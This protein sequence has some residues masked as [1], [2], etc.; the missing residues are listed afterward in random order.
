MKRHLFVRDRYFY[1]MLVTLAIPIALQNFVTFAVNFADNLMVGRLGEYVISG[2]YMGNQLQTFLQFFVTGVESGMLILAAQYWGRQ[3]TGSIRKLVNTAF[4][5][6]VSV[7]TL[8]SVIVALIP[9]KMIALFTNDANVIAEGA[10]YVQIVCWSYIFFGITQMMI[11]A[12]RSVEQSKVG[13]YVSLIALVTNITLNYILIFGKLGF[14]ALGIRGAAIA[15]LISRILESGFAVCYVLFIDQRLKMK[16]R[17]FFRALDTTLA[18]D[19]FKYG[20]PVLLGQIVWAV[21]MLSQAAIIGRMG[22]EATSAVSISGMLNN[23]LFM[24]VLGFSAALGILTGKTVGAGEYE[25][26]KSYAIT[27]QVLFGIVA[28]L[29]GAIILLL[30]NTF[31]GF[32][33]ITDQTVVV[34]KQFIIVTAIASVGRGYQG[35]CLAGLVKA[36]GDVGFVFK[37]DTIFVFLIVL[38]SALIAM[39][40]FN[41][42]AWVVYAC[43]QSDQI[44]KCFVAVVKINRFNW[45]N[46]LTRAGNE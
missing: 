6:C 31:V 33:E 11:S 32:Y 7:C 37:M 12:M 13:L 23:L 28:V 24:V 26:M 1:T 10:S 43:L 36:G 46:N 16:V 4:R 41:A 20:T 2:V 8:F 14:P 42:P 44:L 39:Y 21:N 29:T 30:K 5:F 40:A 18:R 25:K 9:D 27:A 35:T 22:V 45:M 34:A 38:P 17:D 3:D 19:L 15:T